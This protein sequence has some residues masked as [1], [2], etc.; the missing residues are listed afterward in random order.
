MAQTLLSATQFAGAT[1]KVRWCKIFIN[2]KGN[3]ALNSTTLTKIVG[4]GNCSTLDGTD[5]Q[6][7]DQ[8]YNSIIHTCLLSKF[9]SV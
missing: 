9:Q 4:F 5:L 3:E 6:K 1:K 2:Q 8:K 7:Y